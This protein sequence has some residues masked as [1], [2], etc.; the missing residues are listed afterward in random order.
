MSRCSSVS[1]A[2]VLKANSAHETSAAAIRHRI[3][4]VFMVFV[5]L[6]IGTTK[7]FN[8]RCYSKKIRLHINALIC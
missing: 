3:L 7:L 8:S 2:G 5:L 6:I 1:E 4:F